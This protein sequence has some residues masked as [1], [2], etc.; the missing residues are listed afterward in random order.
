MLSQP[1]ASAIAPPNTGASTGAIPLM[2]P[3]IARILANSCP[4]NKSVDMER[5]MTMLPAAAI[6]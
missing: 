6:P 5:A 2:E 3:T 1:P 4:E